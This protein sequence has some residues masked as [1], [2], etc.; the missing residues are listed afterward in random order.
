MSAGS[1]ITIGVFVLLTTALLL[2][3]VGV[4]YVY[5]WQIARAQPT[6][7]GDASAACFAEPVEILRDRH[8][9]PHI[10]ARSRADL[11][12]AQGYVH[13][14]DRIWQ[15]EQNR[16]AAN[17]TLAEVFGEAALEADRFSRTVGFRRAA[18]AEWERLDEPSRQVLL[19]YAEG[20]NTYLL[21]RPKRAA[22]ELNLLRVSPEP[23][24]AL[25]T[26]AFVKMVTWGLSA[27]WESE[28][29]RVRLM[30]LSDPYRA[31]ELEP[32]LPPSTPLIMESL[33][34]EQR[35]RLVNAAGLVLNH[36]EPLHQWFGG[37]KAGQGSNSWVV[38]PK[39]SLTKRPVLANDPHL[40]AQIPGVWYENH[41]SAPDFEVTGACFAGCPGVLIGHNDDLAWGLTNG[42][43]DQQDLYIERPHPEDDTRFE[44][45]GVWEQA[46]I[47]EETIRVRRLQQPELL[48]VVV[49]RHGPILTNLLPQESRAVSIPLAVRWVGHQ[50][51]GPLQA[52][53]A[54]NVAESPDE[55]LS[56]LQLWHCP[57]QNVVYADSRGHIGYQLSG[58]IPIRGNHAGVAPVPGWTSDYEWQRMIPFEELPHGLDPE[59]GIIVTANNKPVGDDYPYFLGLEFDPGWRAMR[60]EEMLGERERYSVRDMEEIQLDTQSKY[61]AELVRWIALL[62]SDDPWEK[63]S[64]QAI[65]KWNLRMDADS[66]AALVYHYFL[67]EML[68]MVFGDKLGSV[69]RSYFG[70]SISPLFP[71]SS[72][73]DRAQSK[74]LDLINQ[75]ESSFWYMDA[76]TGKPRS[77]DQLM[78]EALTRAVRRI[79]SEMGDSALKWF[80]GKSHQLAYA[81]PLGSVRLLRN[82]FNR[83]P[84]PVAG[85]NT[86]TL[87]TRQTSQLPL[88]LV[89]VIPSYRQIIEVGNW[90]R[91]QSVTATGQS[92]HPLSPNYD[93]QMVMW[94]EGVYHT[95]PWSRAAV[96]KA[97]VSRLRLAPDGTS[98]VQS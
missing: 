52:I 48:R 4:L 84:F 97:A 69:R 94:R 16:R 92:G 98:E 64:I 57:S 1:L 51:N 82:L 42:G 31:S 54:L 96:E 15:M 2:L 37:A 33:G 86:T 76:R 88:G 11:F 10:Y 6:T 59:S 74:L 20:V 72:H 61:A 44:Y 29:T 24:N 9:I 66:T 95:M 77:R 90:D 7:N 43:V 19:W 80:W 5:W 46:E 30:A 70:G 85:D 40:P 14:Q 41:L 21:A 13:A 68:E 28:L 39:H 55:L 56:A 71:F 73:M 93:D 91:M 23:W 12:R 35:A 87:Q 53:L 65:R 38:A 17:G 62:N 25:D 36:L 47:F 83:G 58:Q 89:Q 32:E 34:S 63:V 8:G 27:N 50:S 60:I 26:L 45:D 18:A 3:A 79:R 78:Q 75:E 22:P 67:L 49:S 81:H